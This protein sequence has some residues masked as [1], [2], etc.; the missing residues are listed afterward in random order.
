MGESLQSKKFNAFILDSKNHGKN[1]QQIKSLGVAKKIG[2]KR[3]PK[4]ERTK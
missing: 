1:E 3:R 4:S 2:Q